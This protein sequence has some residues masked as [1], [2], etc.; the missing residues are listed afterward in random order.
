[1]TALV[2]SIAEVHIPTYGTI[3]EI[4]PFD[5]KTHFIF[6]IRQFGAFRYDPDL[7]LWKANNQKH[8]DF[9]ATSDAKLS[10]LLIG[11]HKWTVYN[12]SKSCSLA[13]SYT[14][15]L[16]LTGCSGEEFTCSDGSRVA[17]CHGY[18]GYIRVKI[19]R[20]WG[21]KSERT[22]NRTKLGLF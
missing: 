14:T 16:K 3:T 21:K 18:D 1:M 22:H 10:S 13:S 6:I 8:K 17:K 9:L 12:D 2:S 7:S 5:K 19:F 15:V 11:P 4:K 20:G